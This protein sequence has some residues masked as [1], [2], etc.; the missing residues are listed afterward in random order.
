MNVHEH[1]S[2]RSPSIRLRRIGFPGLVLFSF[3][4]FEKVVGVSEN[5][6][7]SDSRHSQVVFFLPD[8]CVFFSFFF[9]FVFVFRFLSSR[10]RRRPMKTPGCR[11]PDRRG[12]P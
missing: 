7:F 8:L 6:W 11:E 10:G 2:D 9:F 12:P 3:F 1:P 5:A 4:V